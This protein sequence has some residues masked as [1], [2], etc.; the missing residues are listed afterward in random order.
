MEKYTSG[1]QLP[2]GFGLAL[3]QFHAMDYFF[4]L[5]VQEQQH[6]IDHTQ[7]IQSKNEMLEY[8]QSIVTVKG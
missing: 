5:P 2:V 1:A 3:E 6:I 7:T 8:V 4:A